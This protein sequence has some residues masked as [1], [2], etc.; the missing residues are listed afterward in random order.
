MQIT[1]ANFDKLIA[2]VDATPECDHLVPLLIR[3]KNASQ[4]VGG[5][6]VWNLAYRN[7]ELL[8]NGPNL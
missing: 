6:L 3:A 8:I 5:R 1:A 2:H 4:K 7:G